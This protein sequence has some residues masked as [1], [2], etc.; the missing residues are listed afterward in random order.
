MLRVFDV[1][2]ALAAGE[3]APASEPPAASTFPL[4]I[5]VEGAAASLVPVASPRDWLPKGAVWDLPRIIDAIDGAKR[6]IVVQ[7]LTYKTKDRSGES[8]LDLEDALERAAS[9]GVSVRLLCADWS[10]RKGTIEGLQA[11]EEVPNIDVS[12]VTI[13]QHS[14]GFIPFARVV[15]A[16]YLAVDGERGWIGTSNWEGD[17]FFKSR[18]VGLFIEGG[19]TPRKLEAIFDELWTGP[20][21]RRVDPKASYEAPRIAE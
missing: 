6:R 20:Y 12:L 10:Q 11:L 13:P 14:G 17:Y 19:P 15:H 18:N 9:R 5:T 1:D 21:A 7:V 2:W 4:R 16:K 8:F 3:P